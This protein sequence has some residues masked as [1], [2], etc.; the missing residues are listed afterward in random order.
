MT[1]QWL[2]RPPGQH[3]T[4][5]AA[6]KAR[7][8][9][10]LPRPGHRPYKLELDKK[11]PGLAKE[12]FG[13]ILTC[14]NCAARYLVGAAQIGLNGRMVRCGKCHHSWFESADQVPVWV[15]SPAAEG[16]PA[17]AA[18]TA[19]AAVELPTAPPELRPIPPGSNLPALPGRTRRRSHAL[20]WLVLILA[21][22]GALYG[23]YVERAN[24]I[25]L[26]P[27]AARLYML[28]HLMPAGGATGLEI[29]GVATERVSEDGVP[30][31]HITG[32]V[33]NV[34]GEARD[35]P[36]IAAVLK[37]GRQQNLQQ[38]IFRPAE[39]R[40][41][42]GAATRFS[43]KVRNPAAG[44]TDLDVEFLPASG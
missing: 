37:D 27:P 23:G 25:T 7:P 43:T 44:A 19:A 20:G 13:M 31:L 15:E 33:A 28:L 17:P 40:L 5:A 8:G 32:E 1:L 29:R 21:L 10:C 39:T 18:A 22:A 14:P 4:G 9:A 30:V 12:R 35:I 42:P 36:L 41:A 34:A 2:S 6:G 3:G 26:W 38:W 24:I 11:F 16:E